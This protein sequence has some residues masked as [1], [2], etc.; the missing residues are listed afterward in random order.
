MIRR[1]RYSPS[2]WSSARSPPPFRRE[3]VEALYDDWGG[4]EQGDV[5]TAVEHVLETRDWIDEDHIV[6]YGG[7]S[8]YWQMVQYPDLYDAGIASVGVRT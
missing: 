1:K 5:A 2:T 8:A 7:Y 3:F 6:V 4:A